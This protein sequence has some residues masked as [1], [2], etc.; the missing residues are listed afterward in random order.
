M[1]FLTVLSSHRKEELMRFGHDR[2]SFFSIFLVGCIII[3]V[4]SCATTPKT[5][6]PASPPPTCE[7]R[8][9]DFVL[10]EFGEE[11]IAEFLD[12]TYSSKKE[13]CWLPM[14]KKSLNG[15]KEIPYRHLKRAVKEFNQKQYGEY[16]QEAVYRY[17]QAI[18][19]KKEGAISYG[20]ADKRFLEAYVRYAIHHSK[21]KESP[22]LIRA[23]NICKRL[24]P[25]IY[26]RIFK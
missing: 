18:I 26:N 7:E 19:F 10:S 17:F 8:L 2:S 12:D 3:G 24:D 6:V 5:V 13:T 4:S 20:E 1:D 11:E 25:D 15:D 22:M 21:S 14:I 9:S 23:K 16:F